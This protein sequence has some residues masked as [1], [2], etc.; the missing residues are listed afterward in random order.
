MIKSLIVSYFNVV[1]KNINDSIPKTIISFLVNRVT[2]ISF[3]II[4]I[5]ELYFKA[6]N[7]SERELVNALYH[8]D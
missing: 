5:L 1:K 7:I 8:E 2:H 6:L 4:L 3:I